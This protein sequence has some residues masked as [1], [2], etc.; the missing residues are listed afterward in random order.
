MLYSVCKCLIVKN[1]FFESQISL[2][3]KTDK[4]YYFGILI[5]EH[6]GIPRY[7]AQQNALNKNK[8]IVAIV[9]YPDNNIFTASQDI[10]LDTFQ[11]GL[12]ASYQP[13]W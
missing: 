7:N 12:K 8:Q 10:F 13:I 6:K 1:G 11:L 9:L 3:D 2:V 4:N 5:N